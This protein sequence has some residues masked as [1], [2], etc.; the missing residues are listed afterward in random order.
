M[1]QINELFIEH[2]ETYWGD[3]EEYKFLS[4]LDG[5]ITDATEM[6]AEGERLIRNEITIGIKAYVLPEF[7]DNVYGKTAEMQRML[8]PSTVVFGYEGDAKNHQVK[9]L[10]PKDMEQKRFKSR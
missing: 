1:N 6:T 3:K 5:S 2:V 10:S 4:S 9:P 7:T 8:S